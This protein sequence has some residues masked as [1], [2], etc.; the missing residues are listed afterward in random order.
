MT[1]S[2]NQHIAENMTG[3]RHAGDYEEFA[4]LHGFP[5]VATVNDTATSGDWSF[6]VSHDGHHW[7]PM[8]QTLEH[9]G[10][11]WR[12]DAGCTMEGTEDEVLAKLDRCH[13][14]FPPSLDIE[15]LIYDS[16]KESDEEE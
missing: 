5:I 14:M 12:I 7:N 11:H 8:W 4:K 1:K 3:R 13:G 15:E 6:I 16:H 10:F 9:D 2:R